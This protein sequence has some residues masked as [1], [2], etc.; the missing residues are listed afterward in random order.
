MGI[1]TIDLSIGHLDG[2]KRYLKTQSLQTLSEEPA[3][4]DQ[5]RKTRRIP[6]ARILDRKVSI[7]F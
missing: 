5:T 7:C 6:F 1:G 2:I 3:K 4:E